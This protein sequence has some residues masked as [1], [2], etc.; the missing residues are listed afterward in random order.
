MRFGLGDRGGA[1]ADYRRACDLSEPGTPDYDDANDALR[2][3]GF[4]D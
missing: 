1:S 3:L 4:T 2:E